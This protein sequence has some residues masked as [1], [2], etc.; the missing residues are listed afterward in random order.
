M[1]QSIITRRSLELG[2]GKNMKKAKFCDKVVSLTV[3]ESPFNL[4]ERTIAIID[5]KI[6]HK[7]CLTAGDVIEITG[8]TTV[9]GN[10]G[11]KIYA[12]LWCGRSADHG[13]NIR[14][15]LPA[16]MNI[17]VTI[18]EKVTIQKMKSLPKAEYVDFIHSERLIASSLEKRLLLALEGSIVSMGMLL[19]VDMLGR[20][21]MFLVVSLRP[22]NMSA[23]VIDSKTTKISIKL[24]MD[25]EWQQA[26]KLKSLDNNNENNC[27][28]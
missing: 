28:Q 17:S 19:P 25:S 15:D 23:S 12:V 3:E 18:G 5:P 11:P 22:S 26:S 14:I 4:K 24:V 20:T 7:F 6:M 16:R 8:K 10:T 13:K 21:N 9:S 1:N 27:Q 2:N